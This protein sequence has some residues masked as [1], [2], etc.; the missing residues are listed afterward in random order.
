MSNNDNNGNLKGSTKVR[1]TGVSAL[2]AAGI[3]TVQGEGT[4]SPPNKEESG[5]TPEIILGADLLIPI[6]K[7]TDGQLIQYIEIP[8]LAIANELHRNP[9]FLFEFDP[10]KF[11]EFIAASY[12]REGWSVEL[13]PRSADGGRDVIATRTDVGSLRVYDEV[14]RYGPG[15]QVTAETVRALSGVVNGHQNVSKGVLTTTAE[16]APG[17]WTDAAIEPLMP[18]RLELRDGKRLLDWVLSLRNSVS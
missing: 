14:K 16:F 13:T 1:I 11:E 4:A 15:R 18:H 17:V 8:W 7:T 3:V 2:T 9:D 6:E 12:D 10:R 5:P